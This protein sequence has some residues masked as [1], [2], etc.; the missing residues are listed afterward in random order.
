MNFTQLQKE[1]DEK[2][3]N[4][5][6]QSRL[7]HMMENLDIQIESVEK[8]TGT[9][10]ITISDGNYS[11]QVLNTRTRD[12]DD[13]GDLAKAMESSVVEILKRYRATMAARLHEMV[14]PR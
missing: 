12:N 14:K 2:Q 10:D 4:L 1:I 11:K 6:R 3:T 8:G 9:I 5:A 7:L 13:F